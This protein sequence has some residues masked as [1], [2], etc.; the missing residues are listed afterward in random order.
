MPCSFEYPASFPLD[1]IQELIGILRNGS[2]DIDTKQFAHATWTVQGYLQN[3]LIG[4]PSPVVGTAV[5]PPAYEE[6]LTELHTQL[7][8]S[9]PARQSAASSDLLELIQQYVL[10]LLQAILAKLLGL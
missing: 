9:V 2:F 5:Q 7:K 4:A 8:N 1:C 10:P 3:L 6:L